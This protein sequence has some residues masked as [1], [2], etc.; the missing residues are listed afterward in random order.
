MDCRRPVVDGHAVDLITYA[1]LMMSIRQPVTFDLQLV[2]VVDIFG[3]EA[4]EFLFL[5]IQRDARCGGADEEDDRKRDCDL[6]TSRQTVVVISL[7]DNDLGLLRSV[8]EVVVARTHVVIGSRVGVTLLE[9]LFR[10]LRE[11][12]R[13]HVELSTIPVLILLA[14]IVL[15]RSIA[16]CWILAAPRIEYSF[17]LVEE[18][19]TLVVYGVVLR[20]RVHHDDVSAVRVLPSLAIVLVPCGVE[21]R[22]VELDMDVITLRA[23]QH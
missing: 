4:S 18:V 9:A 15:N 23:A 10:V 21:V 5:H 13:H 17:I 8:G 14:I 16:T 12:V 7:L 19:D 3:L 2:L 1:A 22:T 6:G 20:A 11:S